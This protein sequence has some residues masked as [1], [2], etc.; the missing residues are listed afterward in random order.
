M[1]KPCGPTAAQKLSG[2]SPESMTVSDSL[3]RSYRT[4]RVVPMRQRQIAELASQ[5]R[6]DCVIECLNCAAK[7]VAVMIFPNSLSATLRVLE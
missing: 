4:A 7:P 1:R 2:N 5:F 3:I 6:D